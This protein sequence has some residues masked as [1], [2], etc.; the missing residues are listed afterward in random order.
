MHVCCRAGRWSDRAELISVWWEPPLLLLSVCLF[1]FFK[2]FIIPC[3]PACPLFLLLFF[4]FC[5]RFGFKCPLLSF[6]WS[7][8]CICL[9]SLCP[10]FIFLPSLWT[11]PSPWFF[12]PPVIQRLRPS[13]HHYAQKSMWQKL[14]REKEK[15]AQ[16]R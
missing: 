14:L 10:F 11:F 7:F 3:R 9:L 5:L 15:Q 12:N 2:Y 16:H 6:S 13:L 8:I 4:L 1:L